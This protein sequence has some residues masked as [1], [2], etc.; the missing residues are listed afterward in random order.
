VSG[1]HGRRAY[2]GPRPAPGWRR[3]D[4]RSAASPSGRSRPS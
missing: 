4:A 3:T 2:R 1:T